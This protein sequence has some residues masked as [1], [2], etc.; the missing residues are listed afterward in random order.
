PTQ[1]SQPTLRTVPVLY[2]G[3]WQSGLRRGPVGLNL[4][5]WLLDILREC[6]YVLLCCWC[7]KELLD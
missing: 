2:V 5:Y 6:A 4:S 7:I 1:Y 3:P